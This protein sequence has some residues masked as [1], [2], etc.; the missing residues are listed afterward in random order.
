MKK[1]LSVLMITLTC[2]AFGQP[3]KKDKEPKMAPVLAKGYYLNP[4]GDTVKGEVQTNYDNELDIYKGF[5]FRVPGTTKV[6]AISSKKAKGYGYEG[7]HFVLFPY[8][9]QSEVYLE[10]LVSGRLNFF[11]F[12]FNET[13]E[14]R[15]VISSKYYIQDTKAD[16]KEKEMRELKA[17]STKFYK[18]DLKPYMKEQPVTWNDL[19][20]FTF[21]KEAVINAIK[22][23][24][25]YYE[26]PQ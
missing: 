24:N 7:H 6:V 22:E 18:K 23:F 2:V 19:D 9:S 10:Q 8:D 12:K 4:K 20:K 16:E 25:K 17:I 3:E 26:G 11:E 15:P 5:N 14:G 21:N 1:F 13:K